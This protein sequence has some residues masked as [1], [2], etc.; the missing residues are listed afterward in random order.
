MTKVRE[1]FKKYSI[2]FAI[3]GMV[4]IVLA[5]KVFPSLIF[6]F[7]KVPEL[8]LGIREAFA[9]LFVVLIY[10]LAAG[11]RELRFNTLGT[12]YGF[13]IMLYLFI[14]YGV[15]VL[16]SLYSTIKAIVTP[17]TTSSVLV[18]IL[19]GF[20]AAAFVGIVEEFTFRAMI[21]GGLKT[22]FGKTKKAVIWAAVISGVAFG[23]LHVASEVFSGS[24]A[25]GW[26]VAQVIGKTIQT[27]LAGFVFALIYYKTRNIWSVVILHSFNDLFLF[28][29]DVTEGVSAPSYVK[30]GDGLSFVG[31]FASLSYLFFSVIAIPMIIR[32]VRE[33]NKEEDFTL[34]TQDD[35]FIPRKVEFVKRSKKAKVTNEQV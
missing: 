26:G 11:S 7:V 12:K 24:I 20:I 25:D 14:I 8:E 28:M 18:A 10:W 29:L 3:L 16:L 31:L 6:S 13:R 22:L 17:E 15:F 9:A 32:V 2:L 33:I 5:V 34:S 1:F 23:F 30:T 21:F 4:T 35:E 19:N 27:G